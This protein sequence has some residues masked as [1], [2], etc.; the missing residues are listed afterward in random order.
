[1]LV[2]RTV[3]AGVLVGWAVGAGAIVQAK[4]ISKRIPKVTV[5]KNTRIRGSRLVLHLGKGILNATL[6]IGAPHSTPR[7]CADLLGSNVLT[8][9]LSSTLPVLPMLR[10]ARND[11]LPR[12]GVDS[13]SE[14]GMTDYVPL[15]S[16]RPR[17]AII[18][19]CISDVPPPMG[20]LLIRPVTHLLDV[21]TS[22][23]VG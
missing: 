12:P 20:S 8:T 10:R 2:G 1:M 11:Q 4:A 15:G 17:V 7:I 13:G 5:A 16:P 14:A 23:S 21:T 6:F 22:K 9:S 18:L 19:R 3:G